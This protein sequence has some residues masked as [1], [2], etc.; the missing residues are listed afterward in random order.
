[1]RIQDLLRMAIIVVLSFTIISSCSMNIDGNYLILEPSTIGK[2]TIDNTEIVDKYNIPVIRLS[3][4]HIHENGKNEYVSLV[5]NNNYKETF[6]VSNKETTKEKI[7]YNL[8]KKHYLSIRKINDEYY[9]YFSYNSLFKDSRETLLEYTERD[10]VKS[11]QTLINIPNKDSL[12]SFEEIK[13]YNLNR[14]IKSN[15]IKCITHNIYHEK[16]MFGEDSLIW[17]RSHKYSYDKNG[18]IINESHSEVSDNQIKSTYTISY[19]YDIDDNVIEWNKVAQNSSFKQRVRLLYE[20][21]NLIKKICEIYNTPHKY[22]Y[23]SQY[24]YTDSNTLSEIRYFYNGKLDYIDKYRITTNGERTI[25]KYNDEGKEIYTNYLDDKNSLKSGYLEFSDIDG[26]DIPYKGYNPLSIR[27]RTKFEFSYDYNTMKTSIQ[28]SPWMKKNI[29]EI[30]NEE[31]IFDENC[32]PIYRYTREVMKDSQN[33]LKEN[34]EFLLFSYVYDENGNW[35]IRRG[36]FIKR[37]GNLEKGY[38][39]IIEKR[40]ITYSYD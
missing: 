25:T 18:K 16:Q 14:K 17:V 22:E 20:N 31:Y 10:K 39:S 12:P 33:N 6:G 32:N 3:S 19:S 27:Q 1:M 8:D 11:V 26:L 36:T 30:T 34:N 7:T 24:L 23:E 38:N 21:N 2:D 29:L 5:F 13:D 9:V 40:E 4:I 15:N 37:F 28:I 35:I